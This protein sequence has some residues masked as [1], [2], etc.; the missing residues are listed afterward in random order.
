[1]SVA[2]PKTDDFEDMSHECRWLLGASDGVHII[3]CYV[4]ARKY[5]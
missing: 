4:I 2:S 3:N 1:M 5:Q